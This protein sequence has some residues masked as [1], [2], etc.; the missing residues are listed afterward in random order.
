VNEIPAAVAIWQHPD[1]QRDYV[2]QDGPLAG[3]RRRADAP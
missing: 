2:W 3:Y 1:L